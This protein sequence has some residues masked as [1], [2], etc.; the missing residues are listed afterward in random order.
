MRADVLAHGVGRVFESPLPLSLYVFGAA[1]TVVASFL[2]RAFSGDELRTRAR[3]RLLGPRAAHVFGL[4]I[5]TAGVVVLLLILVSGTLDRHGGLTLAPLLF[6]V[7][8]IVST[9][10]LCALVDG[11]WAAADP[12]ATAEELYRIEHS[13]VRPL[14]PPWWLGPLLVYGLFWF[15][16][17]SPSG[18]QPVAI[19]GVVLAYSLFAFTFRRRFGERWREVDPLSILFGFASRGAPFELG[20]DG[21]HYRGPVSGLDQDRPLTKAAFA[22]LFVVLG[23]TTLDN[24]RETVAWSSFRANAR[25]DVLPVALTDSFFLAAFAL[26]FL[27]PFLAA[28][29]VAQR[30]MAGSRPLWDLARRFAWSLIPIGVAYLLAHNAPLLM[31]GLPQI[32]RELSDPFARGWNLFGTAGLFRTYVPSPALVW[33]MEIA[34]IVGGHVLGVL[35]AHRL[36]VRLAGSH[37]AA[38]KSQM[39]LTVLMSAFTVTTL[40][41]LAQPLVV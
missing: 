36:A 4:A 10:A 18:F 1:A 3:R 25:V 16:L 12:W 31:T 15:E 24:V 30:W 17:V 40:W 29:V 2:I 8:L 39:A 5:K 19:V 11:W 32:V 21:L 23:A 27:V 33:F 20:D 7:V 34:L 22:S 14:A 26:L 6:W 35:V 41:L 9:A 28:L 38:V 37:S 13:E